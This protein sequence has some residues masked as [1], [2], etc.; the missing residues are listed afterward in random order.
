MQKTD[1]KKKRRTCSCSSSAVR[2]ASRVVQFDTSLLMALYSFL[3]CTVQ[4][5]YTL[6][7]WPKATTIP[8]KYIL[9]LC[10]CRRYHSSSRL[11][12]LVISW[13]SDA[14]LCREW[15][16]S[17]CISFFSY[18][19]TPNPPLAAAAATSRLRY[20]TLSGAGRPFSGAYRK[21]MFPCHATFCLKHIANAKWYHDWVEASTHAL[22][23]LYFVQRL[24]VLG[25]RAQASTAYINAGKFCLQVVSFFIILL[26]L[27]R[28]TC[29]APFKLKPRCLFGCCKNSSREG[30]AIYYEGS[31]LL[32][33]VEH[34]LPA[35]QI[36]SVIEA[37]LSS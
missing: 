32:K 22:Q 27:W 9:L 15:V 1:G 23:P 18:L 8:D 17:Y 28:E 14:S 37:A 6:A 4:E 36:H 30:V 26:W 20:K 16:T 3:T 19:S 34:C 35:P 5:T 33:L 12:F 21:A 31:A 24:S 7:A 2:L 11:M 25:C 29:L 13:C 10:W